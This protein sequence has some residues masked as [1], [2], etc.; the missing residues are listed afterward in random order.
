MLEALDNGIIGD[1]YYS[2][3]SFDNI[4]SAFSSI[5]YHRNYY[6]IYPPTI[7]SSPGVDVIDCRK[8]NS[9]FTEFS[10]VIISEL[11]RYTSETFDFAWDTF[12]SLGESAPVLSMW[13]DFLNQKL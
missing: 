10:K 7:L 8:N 9:N 1:N 5:C 2:G 4:N 12:D 3:T 13:E 6:N 11:D